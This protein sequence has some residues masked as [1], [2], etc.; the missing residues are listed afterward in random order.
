MARRMTTRHNNSVAPAPDCVLA[1]GNECRMQLRSVLTPGLLI[2]AVAASLA[3]SGCGPVAHS[4]A[5]PKSAAS[6]A[7]SHPHRPA[8]RA[9]RPALSL[10]PTWVSGEAGVYYRNMVV[11]LTW[12]NI[13]PQGV[14]DTIATIYR[15][16]GL[17]TILSTPTRRH[18]KFGAPVT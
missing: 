6:P 15:E 11:V 9:T 18:L 3:L 17:S 7:S 5:A 14:Y 8:T 13:A 1:R 10:P 12:H 16:S 2:L 4:A